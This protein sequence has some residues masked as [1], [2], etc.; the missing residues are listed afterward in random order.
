MPADRNDSE[1]RAFVR[2]SKAETH[3]ETAAQL[4]ARFGQDR[5]WSPELVAD[6]TNETNRPLQG[7][8]RGWADRPDILAFIEERVG[9][10]S[11]EKITA[12]GRVQF[13]EGQFPT[14]STVQRLLKPIKAEI[15]RKA[16]YTPPGGPTTT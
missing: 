5:A 15:R 6:V 11:V 16:R 13:G 14:K 8:R 3:A 9:L 12:L 2:M 10:K 7:A 4:A 1:I